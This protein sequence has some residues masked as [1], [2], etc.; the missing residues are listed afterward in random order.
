MMVL[1]EDAMNR[2]NFT[3]VS[4]RV[5]IQNACSV[6]QR[7][8]QTKVYIKSLET[9]DSDR[10][11]RNDEAGGSGEDH[12]FSSFDESDE[13]KSDYFTG[14]MRNVGDQSAAQEQLEDSE[15]E[16]EDMDTDSNIGTQSDSEGTRMIN[17]RVANS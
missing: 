14:E 6:V 12:V 15:S 3:M 11:S 8:A 7:G 4:G 16:D 13:T 1:N 9:M 2:L 5:V 17:G 10:T